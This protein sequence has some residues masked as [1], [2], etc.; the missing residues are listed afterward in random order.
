LVAKSKTLLLKNWNENHFLCE[1]YNC[2]TGVGAEK[3]S[4][5]DPFY[6]WGA[7]LGFMDFIESGLVEAP[8]KPLK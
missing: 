5:S 3:G 4:Q 2:L 6:H 7:L 1:N 8:E